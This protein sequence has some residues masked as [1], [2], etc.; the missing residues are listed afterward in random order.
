M[1]VVW[2]FHAAAI[3]LLCCIFGYM[4]KARFGVSKDAAQE[5]GVSAALRDSTVFKGGEKDE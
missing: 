4:R 3:F 2:G 5:K 1:A